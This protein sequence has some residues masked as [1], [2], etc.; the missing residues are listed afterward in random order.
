[1]AAAHVGRAAFAPRPGAAAGRPGALAAPDALR[2]LMHDAD[3]G[4]LGF[5]CIAVLKPFLGERFRELTGRLGAAVTIR[6][7]L[8][9]W[10]KPAFAVHKKADRI[11]A[12]S[13]AVHVV[14]WTP[15]EVRNTLR[16]PFDIL[17]ADPL[18]PI[19]GGTAWEPWAP[20]LAASR[21]LDALADLS[22]R[23]PSSARSKVS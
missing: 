19:Y 1:M 5:D 11:A 10:S 4:L 8:P 17:D 16:I 20:A 22:A 6:Y 15:D 12:A 14:G 18:V 7:R 3:E 2:E 21:F 23:V 9:A 13:E